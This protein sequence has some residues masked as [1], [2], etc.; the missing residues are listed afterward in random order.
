MSWGNA[1]ATILSGY[2]AINGDRV[3]STTSF[4]YRGFNI[5]QLNL[6]SCLSTDTGP[7]SFDTWANTTNSDNMATYINSLPLNTVLIGITSD[8]P[9]LSLTNNAKS[10]LLAI[11][12]NV[13]GLQW[14]GKVSFVAQIGRQDIALS[15]VAPPGGTNLELNVLVTGNS[16]F[17]R[18]FHHVSYVLS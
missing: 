15:Q 9:L 14:R 17:S 16:H 7:R 18:I 3:L 4:V 8:E 5:V 2:I 6:S 11:G 13:N 12:V 1:D 10:A